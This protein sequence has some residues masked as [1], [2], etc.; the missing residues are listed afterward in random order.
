MLYFWCCVF[1]V[2][3]A[4]G[5]VMFKLAAADISAAQDWRAG[6]LSC[7]LFGALVLYA[8]TTVLWVSILIKLP[9]SRAY[10][11]AL[12]GAAIVPMLAHFLLSEPIP[13]FYVGGLA[14]VIFGLLVIHIS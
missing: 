9:L 11:F 2:S 8:L 10:P 4:I 5:Q 12:L 3:L 7:W 6:L 1:A 14:A 13:P